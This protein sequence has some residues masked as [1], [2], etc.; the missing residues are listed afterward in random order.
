[1]IPADV[2]RGVEGERPKV[3]NA[4]ADA[5]AAVGVIAGGLTAVQGKRRACIIEQ[6]AAQATTAG[7]A[8]G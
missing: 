3:V 1:M 5:G 7:T 4:A 6:T 2:G 8:K